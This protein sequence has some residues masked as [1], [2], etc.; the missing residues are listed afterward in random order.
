MSIISGKTSLYEHY[1]QPNT[2]QRRIKYPYSQRDID[3]A[4]PQEPPNERLSLPLGLRAK[5][6]RVYM[7]QFTLSILIALWSVF[8]V[9]LYVEQRGRQAKNELISS[10]KNLEVATNSLANTPRFAALALIGQ[11]KNVINTIQDNSIN[12]LKLTVELSKQILL[13]MLQKYQKVFLCIFTLSISSSFNVVSENSKQITDFTNSKLEAIQNALQGGLASVNNALNSV[14]ASIPKVN[15]L[16]LE[17]DLGLSKIVPI[18][19]SGVEN[20]LNWS[21]PTGTEDALK[22]LGKANLDLDDIHEEIAK[23]ISVPFD[24]LKLKL[25]D[26]KVNMLDLSQLDANLPGPISKIEF[27]NDVLPVEMVNTVIITVQKL[28]LYLMLGLAVVLLLSVITNGFIQNS[29]HK[30]ESNSLIDLKSRGDA[31]DLV[32]NRNSDIVDELFVTFKYPL[33]Y[34]ITRSSFF[35]T[36]SIESQNRIEWFVA[37]IYHPVAW[38]C[39]LMGSIGLIVIEI[40]LLLINYAFES[41]AEYI[42]NEL[43]RTM[44]SVS[45]QLGHA[46]YTVTDPF[47]ETLNAQLQSMEGILQ[48]ALFEPIATTLTVVSEGI[49][50]IFNSFQEQVQQ[51]LRPTPFLNSAIDSFFNCVVGNITETVGK[52]ETLLLQSFNVTLGRVSADDFGMNEKTLLDT[53]KL[54]DAIT[55]LKGDFAAKGNLLFESQIENLRN[56]YI[57]MIQIQRMPFLI[58]LGFGLSLVF[59]GIW[60][61]CWRILKDRNQQQT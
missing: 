58:I 17:T 53:M 36:R 39:I 47:V 30:S 11:M 1:V 10:C 59:I 56:E 8:I 6:S 48:T 2:L 61:V 54:S 55:G 57:E 49:E 50:T 44:K 22:S 43:V 32:L 24:H 25:N 16:G 46:V 15:I 28:L 19:L 41:L 4:N 52:M 51:L 23:I 7:T 31:S 13:Y 60:T 38:M 18:N 26:I 20:E 40:Q 21:L 35:S 12:G 9:Y 3:S 37:Y 42:N 34:R 14:L 45:V 33:L 27:C 5:L 29:L